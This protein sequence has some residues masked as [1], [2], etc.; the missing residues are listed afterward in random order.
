MAKQANDTD[1]NFLD[2][3]L[4]VPAI[5]GQMISKNSKYVAYTWKGVH[6]N[7]DVFLVPTAGTAQP[8]ALTETS[9]ATFVV[10]FA[11]DSRSVIVGEDGQKR[12]GEIIRSQGG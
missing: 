4:T 6:P 10:N 2:A 3:L 9:E 11:P 7:L 5:Y 8:V 12:K 1:E